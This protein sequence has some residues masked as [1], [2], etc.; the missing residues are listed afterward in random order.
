MFD[1]VIQICD[2][3]QGIIEFPI[4]S[5]FEKDLTNSNYTVLGLFLLKDILTMKLNGDIKAKNTQNGA[6]F[7]INIR[8][9]K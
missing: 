8:L 7:S 1:L 4:N 6:C 5:I 3:A 9:N 2:N